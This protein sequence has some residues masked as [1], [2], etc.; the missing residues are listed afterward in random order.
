MHVNFCYRRESRGFGHYLAAHPPPVEGL[1]WVWTEQNT[2]MK[3][4]LR[5]AL[6]LELGWVDKT[7]NGRALTKTCI[8]FY[9]IMLELCFKAI[10]DHELL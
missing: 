10:R 4:H 3:E 9:N 7:N 5:T 2:E 6:A 1:A 8:K